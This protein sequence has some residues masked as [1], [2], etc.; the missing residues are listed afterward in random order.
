MKTEQRWGAGIGCHFWGGEDGVVLKQ[1]DV[2]LDIDTDRQ[3]GN[4]KNKAGYLE[5]LGLCFRGDTFLKT[6]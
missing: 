4:E 2:L 1:T 3:I 5:V 6:A